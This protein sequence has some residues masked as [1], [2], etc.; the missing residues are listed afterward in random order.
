M[1]SSAPDNWSYI[2]VLTYGR[3]GSTILMRLLN[4]PETV[5]VRGENTNALFY[6]FQAISSV[7]RSKERFGAVRRGTGE[8]WFGADKM[9]PDKFEKT[10]LESFVT[11]VLNPSKDVTHTGF[12]EIRH[13]SDLMNDTEFEEYIAF[14][15]SRFPNVK[16]VFNTRAPLAVSRSGWFKEMPQDYVIDQAKQANIRFA[17]TAKK[18]RNCRLIDYSDVVANGAALQDLF[19]WLGID[20]SENAATAILDIP[21]SHMKTISLTSKV[22]SVI[23]KP[24]QKGLRNVFSKFR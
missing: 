4:L 5:E 7:R 16:I 6:L 8:P 3:S 18:N 20:F 13:L 15:L 14:I 17:A 2:F 10:C 19:N 12:K 22:I 1:Q 21:L 23:P 9:L 24:L 11:T